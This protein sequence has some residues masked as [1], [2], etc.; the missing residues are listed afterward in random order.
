MKKL[1]SF[2]N[3]TLLLFIFSCSTKFIQNQVE[4]NKFQKMLTKYV[5]VSW[6][7]N[8]KYMTSLPP[9]IKEE[10]IKSCGSRKFI[11][12]KIS[13]IDFENTKGTFRCN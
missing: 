7:L 11:L 3:L 8:P 12:V 10:L 1:Y 13:T 9:K 5:T 2:L 4:S 6:K